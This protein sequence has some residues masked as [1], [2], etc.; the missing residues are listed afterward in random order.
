MNK[1]DFE[2]FFKAE[3]EPGISKSD[4]PA[5]RMAWNDLIDSMIRD[6]TLKERAGNW[7]HPKRFKD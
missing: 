7:S 3:I 2:A 4:K 1:K 6:R 5:L